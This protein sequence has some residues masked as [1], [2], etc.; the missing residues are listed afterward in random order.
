MAS[1]LNSS[2]MVR[3]LAADLRLK[4]SDDAVG[5]ILKYCHDRVKKFLADFQCSDSHQLLSLVANKLGTE[6][7]EVLN[8]EELA[9]V[10]QEFL[11]QQE[12]GF[13]NLHLELSGEVLGITLKRLNPKG[14]QLPFVSV[15]DCRGKN[16]RRAYFTKWHELGHLLILT[17]QSRLVFKRTHVADAP[18]SPEEALVDVIAG[19]L[20][21][22]PSIVEAH[23][24]GDI[25]FEA[26]ESIRAAV[27]PDASWQ[28]AVL[29]IAAS[30]PHPCVLLEAR[31]GLKKSE[32]DTGQQ[33]FDFRPA[34]KPSLRAVH[35]SPNAS[36]RKLGIRAIPNFRVP[37]GSVVY[38]AFYDGMPY[39][40]AVEELSLWKSSDGGT[41]EGGQVLVKAKFC[42][43]SV[44]A[45]L[46]PVRSRSRRNNLV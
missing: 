13:V 17:D 24:Q 26:I 10:R 43:D 14:W 19:S 41:W 22:Y 9:A 34:A 42:G 35:V 29:G 6:F 27:W 31:L 33:G 12:L 4:D 8:D 21:F 7:R 44:Q 3:T 45:L 30:W 36:A 28:S 46:I 1:R 5:Q 25:S 2:L 20:A 18:K 16:K 37:T 32:S 38:K 11:D 23:A 15:I 40:E 39:I